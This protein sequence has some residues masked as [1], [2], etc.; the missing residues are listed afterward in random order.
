[1]DGDSDY[2]DFFVGLTSV[3]DFLYTDYTKFVLTVGFVIA[4][5]HTEARY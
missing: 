1:M 5:Q 2:E 4:R 3:L